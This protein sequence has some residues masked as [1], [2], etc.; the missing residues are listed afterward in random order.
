MYSMSRY[1]EINMVWRQH[2]YKGAGVQDIS[3]IELK[4]PIKWSFS[5]Q[6]ACLPTSELVHEYKGLLMVSVRVN[7]D[8]MSISP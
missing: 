7:D 3:M 1:I 5:A 4:S 6:P 8:L 2:Y